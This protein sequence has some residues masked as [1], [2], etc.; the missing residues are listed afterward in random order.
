MKKLIAAM[1]LL[2]MLCM[3][4]ALAQEDLI[5]KGLDGESEWLV[6]QDFSWM[7]D[8]YMFLSMGTLGQPCRTCEIRMDENGHAYMVSFFVFEDGQIEEVYLYGANGVYAKT[9][10]ENGATQRMI[11]RAGD[12]AV[13]L[14]FENEQP[15]AQNMIDVASLEGTPVRSDQSASRSCPVAGI[16]CQ[17]RV[18]RAAVQMKPLAICFSAS[19]RKAALP[20]GVTYC[21]VLPWQ[22]TGSERSM[23]AIRV[24]SRQLFSSGNRIKAISCG[25]VEKPRACAICRPRAWRI[26]VIRSAKWNV[27]SPRRYTR[28]DTR[29]KSPVR[30]ACPLRY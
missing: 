7:P 21:Q 15:V 26:M 6:W 17:E 5:T 18:E 12:E 23:L 13:E 20:S 3:G 16:T 27:T 10:L 28:E 9:E 11:R 14:L 8:P 25:A 1:L 24:T 4:T 19:A 2:A 29:S 30:S 22:G